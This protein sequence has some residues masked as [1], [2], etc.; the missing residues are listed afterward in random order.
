MPKMSLYKIDHF[1]AAHAGRVDFNDWSINMI[2]VLNVER[3][4]G[5]IVT[6]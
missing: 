1:Y 5:A 3:L 4:S 6:T 2:G